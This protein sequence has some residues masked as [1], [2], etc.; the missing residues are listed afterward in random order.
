MGP[1]R[2]STRFPTLESLICDTSPRLEHTLTQ[3]TMR[4]FRRLAG[5]SV[6]GSTTAL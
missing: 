4:M 6:G 2:S 5:T 1:L 3:V